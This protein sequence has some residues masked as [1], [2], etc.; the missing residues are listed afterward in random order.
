MPLPIKKRSK[1]AWVSYVCIFVYILLLFL[2]IY[3]YLY[4]LLYWLTT[5]NFIRITPIFFPIANCH[6]VKE[7]SQIY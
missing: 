3:G 2:V 5:F 1:S 6:K 4:I 7:F